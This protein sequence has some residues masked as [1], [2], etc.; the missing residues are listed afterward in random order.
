[1]SDKMNWGILSRSRRAVRQYR[2]QRFRRQIEGLLSRPGAPDTS[3]AEADFDL[4]QTQYA[5][6][7]EYGYDRISLAGRAAERMASVLS[8]APRGDRPLAYLDLATGDG[9]IGAL[10]AA[11]GYEVSL[12]DQRDWRAQAA[13]ALPFAT[14]DCCQALPYPDNNFDIVSSFNSFE[15]MPDP[16]SAFAEIVRVTKPGGIIYLDFGPLYASALGLHSYRSL[17]MPYPQFL[18]SKH[19]IDARL[20]DI[21]INDLGVDRNELQ[22]V[23]GWTVEQYDKV[24]RH[25]GVETLQLHKVQ[26]LSDLGIIRRYPESFQGR[27]LDFENVICTNIFTVFR[28]Y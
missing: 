25:A 15:H 20:A 7:P 8:H 19:F 28:K 9:T 24:W 21:G 26:N 3:R 2:M 12:C 13:L 16:A 1:M 5:P 17:R 27:D 23:N 4:L 11:A 22:Y 14:A 6:R 18:F 10:F